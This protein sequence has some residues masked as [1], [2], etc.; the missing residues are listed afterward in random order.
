[1]EQPTESRCCSTKCEQLALRVE[2]TSMDELLDDRLA[3]MRFLRPL[4]P[5]PV[6]AIAKELKRG[7]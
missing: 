5:D 3:E 4:N 1:M 6:T 7:I 2:R